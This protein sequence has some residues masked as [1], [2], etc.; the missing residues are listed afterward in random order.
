L[1]VKHS[2]GSMVFSC[3]FCF[4]MVTIV[5]MSEASILNWTRYCFFVGFCVDNISPWESFHSGGWTLDLHSR[6]QCGGSLGTQLAGEEKPFLVEFPEFT[7]VSG[8]RKDP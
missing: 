1:A 4:I 2:D 7:K 6:S 8:T 5:Y 3:F